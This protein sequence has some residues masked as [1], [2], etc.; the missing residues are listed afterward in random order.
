[1]ERSSNFT[2]LSDHHLSSAGAY[3]SLPSTLDPARHMWLLFL[4]SLHVLFFL[5]EIFVVVV[6]VQ[7]L[8]HVQLFVTP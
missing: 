4:F 6:V 1:M 5:I 3:L 8:S 7:S 2:P